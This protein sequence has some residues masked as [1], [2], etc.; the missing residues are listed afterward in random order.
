MNPVSKKKHQSEPNAIV[1]YLFR[2]VSHVVYT[3]RL[4]GVGYGVSDC[5]FF[6]SH[7]S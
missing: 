5:G 1:D 4:Y 7:T 2:H 6:L 3:L